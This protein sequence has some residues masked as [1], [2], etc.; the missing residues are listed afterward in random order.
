MARA[1]AGRSMLTV[2]MSCGNRSPSSTSLTIRRMFDTR[3]VRGLG[4]PPDRRVS[5]YADLRVEAYT[6][7]CRRSN[8]S[9]RTTS[10]AIARS[11]SA[12]RR[13]GSGSAACGSAMLGSAGSVK[14]GYVCSVGRGRCRRA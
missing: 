10:S 2:T 8:S 13:S 4:T 3:S 6:D 11:H 1:E 5:P 14:S 12:S 9:I 7:T